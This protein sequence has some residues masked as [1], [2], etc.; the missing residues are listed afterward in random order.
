MAHIGADLLA[1]QANI[2]KDAEGY[3]EDFLMQYR[4]YKA[5]LEIFTLKPS[6]E[7]KEFADL[8]MFIAQV[9]CLHSGHFKCMPN[10]HHS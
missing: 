5:V 1:L 10:S 4:H 9:T 2:K 8:V 7:S 6:K 3:K